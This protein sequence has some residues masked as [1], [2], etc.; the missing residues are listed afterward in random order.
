MLKRNLSNLVRDHVAYLV[1]GQIRK[2]AERRGTLKQPFA[3][4]IND[5]I[6]QRLIATG[7]F[8]LTQL[9]AVDQLLEDAAP[10]I[11]VRPE[12]GGAFV[13]V[14]ANIGVYTTRYASAFTHIIAIEPNPAAYYILRANLA[15]GR[16]QN[17]VP[18]LVG[19]S[20]HAGTGQLHVAAGG[21]LG[22]SRLGSDATWDQY[23]IEVPL[24]MLDNLIRKTGLSERVSLLKIDVEGHETQ[25]LRGA[26]KTLAQHRPVVCYA[27]PHQQ[28]LSGFG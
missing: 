7:N 18:L 22:W 23:R 2:R 21:M 26:A 25:V 20:D 11:G 5:S 24:D 27:N 9:D 17:V 1:L 19:C 4:P 15:L 14:G 8:E 16:I 3:V 13:D 6:G 12:F 10:L 28:I